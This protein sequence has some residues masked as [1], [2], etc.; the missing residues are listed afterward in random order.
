MLMAFYLLLLTYNK[1]AGSVVRLGVDF[2]KPF[3][4]QI[5]GFIQI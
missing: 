5:Y 2:I 1:M 4:P 3:L